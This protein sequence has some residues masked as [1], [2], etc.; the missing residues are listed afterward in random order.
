MKR[1]SHHT[2]EFKEKARQRMLGENN[3]MYGKKRIVLEET[4]KKMS[5][6]HKGKP[7]GMK[8]KHI[9]EER[10]KIMREKMLGENNPMYGKKKI[11][12]AETKKRMSIGS[13]NTIEKINEKY[14][15][16]S[17]IE[18]MRY[19]PDNIEEKE[20]Q[21]HCKYYKCKNSK[22]KGGWFTPTGNQLSERIRSIEKAGTDTGYF[23]CSQGCKDL[24]PLFNSNGN[25]PFKKRTLSYTNEELET[26][27]NQ[28]KILDNSQCQI[29]GTKI[30][31]HI[32]HIIPKK[33]EPFFALDPVN[34][35]CLCEKCH[36][37]YG[38]S[39]DGCKITDLSKQ[40][41]QL[42]KNKVSQIQRNNWEVI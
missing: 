26:W 31:I 14:Q 4:R 3:P 7:S 23:Y 18:D 34:G 24:C 27:K 38:H 30:N 20:I 9:P 6:S 25:D 33:I 21:V 11:I 12:S 8:G 29:C 28:V 17:K 22:E 35:I 42:N 1:G 5:E 39:D 41:S 37:K 36:F 2:P 19:N 13:K 10:K 15:F 32:H 16:F 40:C